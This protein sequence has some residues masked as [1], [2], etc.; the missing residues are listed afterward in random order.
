MNESETENLFSVRSSLGYSPGQRLR[1]VLDHS[2]VPSRSD[3]AEGLEHRQ[4]LIIDR[5]SSF[6][7]PFVFFRFS[8]DT[9]CLQCLQIRA[10]RAEQ[11]PSIRNESEPLRSHPRLHDL[12]AVRNHGNVRR[13]VS[14]RVGAEMNV[15]VQTP[16]PLHQGVRISRQ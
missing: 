2:H 15:D 7:P 16:R 11:L 12:P 10:L 9:Q 4:H 6:G 5:L 13:S 14:E 1:A 3:R 8:A